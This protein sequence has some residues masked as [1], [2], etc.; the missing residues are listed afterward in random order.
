MVLTGE[1]VSIFMAIWKPLSTLGEDFLMWPL[2]DLHTAVSS[3]SPTLCKEAQMI[4]LVVLR[5]NLD[6]IPL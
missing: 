5:V 6:E 4:S 3:L 2:R 1:G